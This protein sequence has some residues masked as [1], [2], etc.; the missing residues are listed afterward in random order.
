MK[1]KREV[2]PRRVGGRYLSGYWRREYTVL[3]ING[4]AITVKQTDGEIVTH[5][6]AWD[7]RMDRIISQPKTES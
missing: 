5:Y 4:C 3:A 1:R 2:D 6:T 7:S